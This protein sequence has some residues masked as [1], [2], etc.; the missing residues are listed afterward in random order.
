MLHP[1]SLFNRISFFIA[2]IITFSC[3]NLNA[4]NEELWG[5]TH[6]GGVDDA[7][8]IFRAD[9]E[10]GN[11]MLRHEFGRNQGGGP[12]YTKLLE[13]SNGK[14]YGLTVNGGEHDDGVLFEYDAVLGS[15]IKRWDFDDESD[16]SGGNPYGSLIEASNGK[17]YGMTHN[18]GVHNA[19]VIF[20]YDPV[21]NT[22]SKKWDFDYINGGGPFGSLIEASNGKFYG[23]T[24]GG[25]ENYQGVIFEYDLINNIYI[26]KYDFNDVDGIYP[27]GNL[28][29][30]VDGILYG[31]T[32]SGGSNGF[33][34]LFEFEINTGNYNVELD[35]DGAN[36]GRMPMGSLIQSSNGK[37]YGMTYQGGTSNYGVLFEYNHVDD[38]FAKKVDFVGTNG[39]SPYGDLLEANNG[40]LYGVTAQG[41]TGGSGYGTL[42]EFDITNSELNVKEYFELI[43]TGANPYGSLMQA[44]NG[45]L[46]GMAQQGGV[47]VTYLGW[48]EGSSGVLFEYDLFAEELIKRI[49]FNAPDNFGGMPSGDLLQASNGKLYGLTKYGGNY[50][51]GVLF[52]I[53]PVTHDYVKKVDFDGNYMGKFPDGNSLIEA[54]NGKLYG[55]TKSGGIYGFGVFFEYDFDSNSFIKHLD[56]DGVNTGQYPNGSLIEASNGKLYGLT[57]SGGVNSFGVLFEFNTAT[58]TYIKK[59]DFDGVNLGQYPNGNLVEALNNKLFGVTSSGGVNNYGVLFEYDFNTNTLAKKYEFDFVNRG[60]Q[61]VAL[62]SE[63]KLYGATAAFSF[64]FF[65]SYYKYGA[66][67]F[68]YDVNANSISFLPSFSY[69]NRQISPVFVEHENK[70]LGITQKYSNSTS[71]GGTIFSYDIGTGTRTFPSVFNSENGALPTR[72]S[73]IKVVN[74]GIPIPDVEILPDLSADCELNPAVPTANE[75][76][77]LA[78]S[79]ID[80]PIITMGNTV[81]T[82][83]YSDENGNTATQT[84]NVFLEDITAPSL[85]SVD[86]QIEDL[87]SNCEFVIPDYSSFT[88]VTDNCGVTMSQT[89]L[90]GTT[91]TD[92]TQPTLIT[93]TAEDPSGNIA[94]ISFNV[95]LIG[96]QTYY[97]DLDGDGYGDPDTSLV[98]CSQP[99]GYVDNALDCDDNDNSINPVAQEICDGVDNNCDGLVDDADDSVIGQTTWYADTDGDGYGDS[100]NSALSCGQPTGY[101]DNALDCNDGDNAIN[102]DAQEICDG[103]DNDCD[104]LID[105]VDDSIIGLSTW[106]ADIDGDGYGDSNNSILSCGQTTGY[107]DNA[108]DCNDGDN[109]INPDAQ[110][111]CDGIDNDCD[112]LVDD[113]DDSIIGQLVWY[114]DADGDGYGDSSDSVLSCGQPTG[115]VDNALDCDDSNNAINPSAQ[116]ICDGIDNDCDGLVDDADVSIVGQSVW[117]A[118]TD[119]DGYGDIASTVISCNQPMGYVDNAFDCDDNNGLINPGSQEICDG[120]DNDC[121]G[122]V[123]DSDDSLLGGVSWYADVDGDGYGDANSSVVVC[124]Q[125]IGYVD[126][127]LD[128][129]DNNWNVHPDA[130]EVCDGIDNDCDGLVDDADDS[131][132][133]QLLWYL[134]NDGD[135][136]GDIAISQWSCN[137]PDGYVYDNLD[138]NDGNASIY[139]GAPEIC[140]GVDNDCDGLIDDQDLDV[141]GGGLWYADVDGDGYGDITSSIEACNQPL[142]YVDNALDCNDNDAEINPDAVEVCDGVDNNC[143]GLLDDEDAVVI[144]EMEWYADVDGD[145]YGDASTVVISCGQPEGYVGNNTDCNDSNAMVNPGMEESP[146][147]GIDDN[148]NG[149][150][151]DMDINQ[152]VCMIDDITVVLDAN[153]YAMVN[154]E[155]LDVGSTDNC[156][157]VEMSVEPSEFGSEDVGSNVISLTV[158]DSSGNSSTCYAIAKVELGGGVVGGLDEVMI[159]PNPFNNAINFRFP[160]TYLGTIITIEIFDLH[161]RLLKSKQTFYDQGFFELKGMESVEEAPYFIKVTNGRTQENVIKTLIKRG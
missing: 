15:Y 134:D 117:Y 119:G 118:D 65:G 10:G 141:V 25:G 70:L 123:D 136:Y 158:V 35:F 105:D 91:I 42:F 69:N 139:P 54:S 95:T 92:F 110:E 147:N 60:P 75:G 37:L 53:D 138:C 159:Y 113:A 1:L 63:G 18:G 109:A 144:G 106:Y 148:C 13:A 107:V 81:I 143:D 80:F 150:G 56:F 77:I 24:Y 137:Q 48:G 50:G 3:L 39:R 155:D 161:G 116:E 74:E 82:W 102:P 41:G 8:V 59:L 90:V 21:S 9:L 88:M 33:G 104:G 160:E 4:Q 43:E 52:E 101:V 68:E 151:D 71:T 2:L 23:M 6:R 98:V 122:L 132:L 87:N 145:G 31:M 103:I 129:D 83:T 45:K 94:S 111:I 27:R 40:N 58:N 112:G 130:Q 149:F 19:G 131:L 86:D 89:P 93:L 108:L 97:S 78:V 72:N 38:I 115:Y 44:T 100:N 157:I 64:S 76:E 22:L 121:D 57:Q 55:M 49:D 114:L 96:Y 16:V 12:M 28:L 153:G 156:G 61:G 29:E 46:Y 99:I 125:P 146:C 120:I 26:K 84:Q 127:A 7:G 152:P 73:L 67:F 14:L 51:N 126:N 133:G 11:Q 66:D 135:G 20:E 5:M 124:G 62:S 32:S 140:D 36:L 47:A 85:T 142:G 128:C 34:V 79:D 17:L 154:P 30:A